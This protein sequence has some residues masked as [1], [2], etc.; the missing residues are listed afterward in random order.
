MVFE[1]TAGVQRDSQESR[2]LLVCGLAPPLNNIGGDRHGRPYYLGSQR[3][4]V[5]PSNS[6]G[7]P[8][9]MQ[10]QCVC[11][12]PHLKFLEIAHPDNGGKPSGNPIIISIRV[13]TGNGPSMASPHR[14]N[15]PEKL[16]AKQLPRFQPP[17]S[18][19]W[20]PLQRACSSQGRSN[21]TA[22]NTCRLSTT[23]VPRSLRGLSSFVW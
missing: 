16:K 3:D 15:P 8:V 18:V 21:Q 4:V 7:D 2:E 19:L 14:S 22:L 11:L 23:D 12:V 17:A 13:L 20:M 1:L 5:R 10:G 9:G 6:T